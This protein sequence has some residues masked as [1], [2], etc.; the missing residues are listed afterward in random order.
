MTPEIAFTLAILVAVIAALGWLRSSPD[1][2]LLGGLTALLMYGVIDARDAFAGLA[3]E[4]LLAVAVLYVVA[5]GL[6]QTGGANFIGTKLLGQPQS[7][8]SAQ[9]RIMLP[10]AVLSAF[11]NNT[12]VVA[13]MMPVI[14]DW[15]KKLRLSVSYLLM[16][17]SFAAILGGL[18]T[19]V[20]T[21]TTLVV[22]GLLMK[23][24][25]NGG[26]LSM[27]EI[28]WVGLP[29]A[30]VGGVYLLIAT[31]WLL[32]ARVPTMTQMDDPREFSVEMIVTPDSALVGKT[33]E[34]A[35]LRHL[36]GMYLMEIDREN[37]VLAAVGS[38]EKLKANDRLVFVGVVE[39]VVD[40]RKIP[41]L[42]PAG[43]HHFQLEGPRSERSLIEAVV[44]NSCPF[45][46]TT[47]R[48]ARFRSH[49]DAAV[50]A[51]ARDGRR[52]RKKIGD[53]ELMP[54]DT[55]LLEANP[56]FI[57]RQRNSR[58]FFLV[59]QLTESAAPR[60][61]RAW[62]ARVILLAM[63]VVV[64]TGLLS[65]LKAALLAAA[66]MIATRCCRGSEAKRAIDLGVLLTMAAGL[67]IGR[68]LQTSGT[69]EWLAGGLIDAIGN[70]PLVVC[71]VLYVV[72]MIFTNIITAKAAAVLLF[73]IAM[74][75]AR[76]L[77]AD[78]MPFAVVVMVASAASFATPIGYQTN[79]MVY[80]P[81]GY[82]FS[83]FLRLGG[84]LSLL[85]GVVTLAILPF[86]WPFFP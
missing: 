56:D 1:L 48:D 35:G 10:T 73:P 86:V 84:P 46:R 23:E 41:G 78:I 14:G 68:A 33:I 53:I 20:G 2:I 42:E 16:P 57:E 54:G 72:T 19:L 12:P 17:L 7:L 28:A 79:L 39:S 29:A 15:A 8:R 82:R 69:A 83:D 71:A 32:P 55:L 85:V 61:E 3:N 58:D 76:S 30:A 74:A 27:F 45:L 11:M 6:R 70:R 18:C 67:G 49:Y 43:D 51:V 77:N 13:T 64:A 65:M 44:S 50:I 63:V 81:G 38:R 36:P 34:E 47:I 31:R 75:A 66:A 62:Y 9:G 24:Q 60:H 26:G 80:G 40:L 25:G 5:E 22:N 52:I 4:G 59:S 21:S 37:E